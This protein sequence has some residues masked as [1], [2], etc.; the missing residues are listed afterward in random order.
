MMSEFDFFSRGIFEA[1]SQINALIAV[2]LLIIGAL[3][4]FYGYK[5]FKFWIAVTWF[6]VFGLLGGIIGNSFAGDMGST[7]F[8][9]IMF[10]VLGAWISFK[11][12]LAGVFLLCG[13]LGFLLGYLLTQE[14]ALGIIIGLVLG[15]LGTLFVKPVVIISTSLSGGIGVGMAL[16]TLL[17][18]ESSLTRV[19]LSIIFVILGLYV[20]YITNNS[21]STVKSNHPGKPMSA[22]MGY[23][24]VSAIEEKASRALT[25]IKD[26]I[27]KQVNENEMTN[28]SREGSITQDELSDH[29]QDLLYRN[30]VT[31]VVLPFAQ[32][33]LYVAVLL[34]IVYIIPAIVLPLVGILSFAKKRHGSLALSFSLVTLFVLYNIGN[35]VN[36]ASIYIELLT[37]GGIAFLSI[38]AYLQ[39]ESG[40]SLKTRIVE[41]TSSFK[42][43]GSA[44]S[45]NN[46]ASPTMNEVIIIF[47][48]HNC[49][50]PND[51]ESKFCGNCGQ[52]LLVDNN[53]SDD[54][55]NSAS[56]VGTM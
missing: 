48:C 50:N 37:V 30:Q 40:L 24:T 54:N 5:L 26:S 2:F 6:I 13:S 25:L 20:Q 7:V 27:K 17:E 18:V 29:L 36:T 34:H 15:V 9:A 4:C 14:M 38:K 35:G 31:R 49:G 12:Y 3:Q 46:T 39:T 33:I 41:V 43:M 51:E 8:F 47:K 1:F 45:L 32:Y 55:K 42:N 21:R 53:T 19:I 56:S 11:L 52:A 28:S 23:G 16:A 44:P 10:A 22:H